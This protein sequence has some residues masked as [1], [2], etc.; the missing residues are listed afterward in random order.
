MPTPLPREK[1]ACFRGV[2]YY[3]Y[4]EPPY[5]R[6]S[7]LSTGSIKDLGGDVEHARIAECE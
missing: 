3:S 7:P 1:T 2:G 6:R 4:T 5:D